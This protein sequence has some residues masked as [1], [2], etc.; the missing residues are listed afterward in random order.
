MTEQAIQH[1]ENPL[2]TDIQWLEGVG[3][4]RA[5]VFRKVGVHTFRDLFRFFPRRYL[6]RTTVTPIRQLQEGIAT[7]IVGRVVSQNM[8]EAGK[9]RF[10]MQVEDE[11]GGRINCV[12]F[13][14]HQ[15]V[16]RLFINGELVALHGSP[17]KFGRSFS[18]THP[19]YDKLETEKASL[20][21]GRIIPLYPGGQAW[22]RVGLSNKALRHI[23]YGLFKKY[24]LLLDENLP[25]SIRKKIQPYGRPYCATG[26]PFS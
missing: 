8:I 21:T 11:S 20:T 19:D 12:W 1:T 14:G 4:R 26:N 16:R 22:D 15:W 7:T 3:P 6:D 25:E 5:E 23:I 18:F 24:G 13:H 2:D 10:E 17:Q 9:K